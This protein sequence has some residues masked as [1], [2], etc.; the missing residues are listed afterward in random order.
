[1][2]HQ[3]PARDFRRRLAEHRPSH[4]VVEPWNLPKFT[5]ARLPVVTQR[6]F[7]VVMRLT[8]W[9]PSVNEEPR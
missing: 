3:S 6:C 5:I 8:L 9:T 1:V 7:L 2:L 4:W